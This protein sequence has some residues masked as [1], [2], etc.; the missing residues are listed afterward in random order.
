M[1]KVKAIVS[2]AGAVLSMYPGE[3]REIDDK[4]AASLSEAGHVEI[5]SEKEESST[6]E[7]TSEKE[8]EPSTSEEAPKKEAKKNEGKRTKRADS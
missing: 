5:L 7:E 4:L 2:F 3:E 8:E 1:A 6:S